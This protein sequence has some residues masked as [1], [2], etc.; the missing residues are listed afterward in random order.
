VYEKANCRTKENFIDDFSV[1]NYSTEHID[2][3]DAYLRSEM[4]AREVLDF[5]AR[6]G[7]D[8][9]F[10][11][12]FETYKS[13]ERDIKQH[14]IREELKQEFGQIDRELDDEGSQSFKIIKL[15]WPAVAIAASVVIAFIVISI[16]NDS[17]TN[18]KIAQEYWP[19]EE[20]LPVRMSTKAPFDDAMNAFKQ[21]KWDESITLL[22]E[23]MPSDTAAY[24]L[25]VVSYLQEDYPASAGFFD[26]VP[27]NSHWYFKSEFRLAL[28]RLAKGEKDIAK[29]R[30]KAISLST[31]PYKTQAAA[32]LEAL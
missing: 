16:Y 19:L 18:V 25:G 5:E 17:S 2:L 32:V 30:L 24:F 10:L 11:E 12:M 3:F 20:G 6:L 27:T 9:E 28:V 8:K 29:S 26:Q 15:L 13:I 22:S 1:M 4:T 31:S 23:R 14:Y 7:Y 21:H